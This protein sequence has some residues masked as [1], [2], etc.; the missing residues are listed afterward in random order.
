MENSKKSFIVR[1]KYRKQIELLDNEKAWMLF[2]AIMKMQDWEVL[3]NADPVISMLLSIM[4]E[5]RK[6]DNEKYEEVCNKN[7]ENVKKRWEKKQVQNDTTV[8][9]RIPL[10]TKNTD[11]D[12]DY[13]NDSKN[14]KK[15]INKE[16]KLFL[17]NVY[18]TEEQYNKI[19]EEY[20]RQ[21]TEDYINRLNN[22][23]GQ[24]KKWA[25]YTDHYLTILTWMRKAKEKKKE[26]KADPIQTNLDI[27]TR[28]TW[29]K[30]AFPLK[31]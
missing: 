16:K 21:L 4:E 31:K 14:K 20:W 13:D 7:R 27:D 2:K 10:D 23:I 6:E 17:E 24:K 29:M 28:P 26:K 22:Y 9:D 3:E 19:V 11:N 25:K 5:E 18:M 30:Q 8:Y 15:K 1:K 12:N